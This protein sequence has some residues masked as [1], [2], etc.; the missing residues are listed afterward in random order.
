MPINS[1]NKG[2][3]YERKIANLLSERF[4]HITGLTNSFRRAVDSGSFFGGKNQSRTITHDLSKATFGD[5]ITPDNFVFNIECKHYKKPPVFSAI[6]NENYKE[7]DSWIAQASQDA[8]NCDKL[9]LIII[10]YNN[11][12]DFVILKTSVS[13]SLCKD[14]QIIQY[15][16]CSIL[17][18]T[19]FL[20]LSDSVFF[21]NKIINI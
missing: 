19:N 3:T 21:T 5:I 9:M 2:S 4:K 10:K 18:L 16:D 20:K 7:W 15:K 6:L 1:K 11:V 14:S 17:K 13:Q 8:K 12:E